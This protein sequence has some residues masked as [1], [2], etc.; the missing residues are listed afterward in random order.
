MC[1]HFVLSQILTCHIIHC[2]IMTVLSLQEEWT[3]KLRG[4]DTEIEGFRRDLDGIIEALQL[5][6]DQ[7]N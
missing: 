5:L 2:L 6:H 4:K 7:S 1:L 3:R